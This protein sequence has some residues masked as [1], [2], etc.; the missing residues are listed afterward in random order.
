MEASLAA[1]ARVYWSLTLV[2][3]LARPSVLILIEPVSL[4]MSLVAF[5]NFAARPSVPAS[6]R[7][8]SALFEARAL[9]SLVWSSVS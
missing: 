2:M 3:D 7:V 1:L 9:S 6:M 5:S 8:T 4:R